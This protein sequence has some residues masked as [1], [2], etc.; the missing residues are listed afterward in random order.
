MNIFGGNIVTI[1]IPQGILI[2][3]VLG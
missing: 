1:L 3:F 2:M